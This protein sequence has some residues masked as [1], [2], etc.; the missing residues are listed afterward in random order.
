MNIFAPQKRLGRFLP[1][2]EEGIFKARRVLL[3]WE[4]SW[5]LMFYDLMFHGSALR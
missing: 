5:K 3:Q 4:V 1:N 2:K